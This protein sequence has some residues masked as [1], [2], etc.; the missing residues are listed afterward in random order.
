MHKGTEGALN[1]MTKWS[2][3]PRYSGLAHRGALSLITSFVS[4]LRA[5]ATPLL[6]AQFAL[7]PDAMVRTLA[8]GQ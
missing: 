8:P 2:V 4:S 5:P 6:I 7:Q 3:S 1:L